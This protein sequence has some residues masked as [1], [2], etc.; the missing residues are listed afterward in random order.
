M[1]LKIISTIIW[2]EGV[3]T[4]NLEHLPISR[5]KMKDETVD[6]TKAY[7]ESFFLKPVKIWNVRTK[8]IMCDEVIL[9]LEL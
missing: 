6:I 5:D 4:D 9:I 2:L 1:L 7:D 8:Q 3:F